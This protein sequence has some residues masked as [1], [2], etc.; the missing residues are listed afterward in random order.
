MRKASP[1][2]VERLVALM[3]EFYAEGGV[4]A[5]FMATERDNLAAL[6]VYRRVGFVNTDRQLLALTKA[7]C[8]RTSP[9]IRAYE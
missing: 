1:N 4:R 2:D 5:M 7:R 9:K 3:A 8:P 6:A